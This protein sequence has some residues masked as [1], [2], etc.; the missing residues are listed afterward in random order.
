MSPCENIRKELE[1]FLCGD[2]DETQR[3]EIQ[4]HLGKCQEC[5]E[6]LR[7]LEKLAGVLQSWRDREP[8]PMMYEK[9]KV[10]L[11]KP[12]SAWNRIFMYSYG[13][14]VAIRFAQVAT[15]VILTLLISNL[16]QKPAPKASE[17]LAPLNFYLKEHQGAVI[18]SVSAELQSR[19]A[20][21]MYV[22]RDNIIYFEFM[23]DHPKFSRPGIIFKGP[24]VRNNIQLPKAPAITKG[25]PLE[26]SQIKNAVDFDPVIPPQ[27]PHDYIL[28]SI[29]KIEDYH[30]LHLLYAMG[31]ETISLFEQPSD[32]QE[33]LVAQDFREFAVYSRSGTDAEFDKQS[34]GTILSWSDGKLSFVLIGGKDMSRL[35]EI[36]QSI[37]ST[38]SPNR[39]HPE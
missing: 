39:G 7:Q 21:R 28:E 29:R 4:H 35:M 25:Q 16:L 20:T 36:V 32:S 10:R 17:N 37:S 30:C 24:L 3:N 14:R 9:L 27:L 15:I 13:K 26:L 19:P 8:S 6:V 23:E 11:T 5:S 22:G 38:E 1:A 33:G 34:K 18:Q 31:M 12:D 2:V